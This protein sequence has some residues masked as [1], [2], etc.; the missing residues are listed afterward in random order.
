MSTPVIKSVGC[1]FELAI[2]ETYK[3][4]SYTSSST[5]YIGQSASWWVA[6]LEKRNFDPCELVA[7]F[8][9]LD[10]ASECDPQK[11]SCIKVECVQFV[12]GARGCVTAAIN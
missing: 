3:L 6:V 11:L 8:K 7:L 5:L 10:Y 12:L 1:S 4:V 9:T 2:F